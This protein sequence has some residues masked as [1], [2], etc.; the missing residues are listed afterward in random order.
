M[1]GECSAIHVLK[2][3]ALVRDPASELTRV[4]E[5]LGF[6]YEPGML[7]GVNSEKLQIEYRREGFDIVDLGEDPPWVNEIA[8]ELKSLG[9]PVPLSVA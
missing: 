2:Y 3:E 5:F 6:E 8:P 9:Y 4:V 7:A 1:E